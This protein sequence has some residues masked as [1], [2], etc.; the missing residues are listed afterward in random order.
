MFDLPLD[1]EA[2]EDP[3]TDTENI[4]EENLETIEADIPAEELAE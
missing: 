3:D 4:A 1:F 2:A